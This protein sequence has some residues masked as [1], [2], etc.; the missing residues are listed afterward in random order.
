MVEQV[1]LSIQALLYLGFLCGVLGFLARDELRL[2]VFMLSGSAL[3]LFYYYNLAAAPL[4]EPVITNAV[5]G[6]VNIAMIAVIALERTTFAM[7]RHNESLFHHF[8]MLTPGQ[9]RRLM[10]SARAVTAE[11]PVS[12]TR[13]GAPVDRLWYVHHGAVQIDKTGREVRVEDPMFVGELAFITGASASASV[14][15]DA[16]ARYLEWD[17]VTLRAM[18]RKSP[19]L[20]VAL[21]AQFNVDLVSKVIRSTPLTV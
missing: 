11:E 14:T 18:T 3:Y 12:L 10:K 15:L 4:W 21:Q 5:L 8:T 7:S 1:G 9:F 20:N 13:Q 16:G 19:R 2:R 6:Y 17:S